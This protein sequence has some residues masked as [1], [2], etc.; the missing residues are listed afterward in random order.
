MVTVIFNL[1]HNRTYCHQLAKKL[2]NQCGTGG[3][4]KND[5]IELQGDQRDKVKNL[6][7]KLGFTVQ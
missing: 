6:L 1:P 7:E 2:K 4:L 3:T 5:Q